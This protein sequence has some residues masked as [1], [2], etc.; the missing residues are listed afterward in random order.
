MFFVENIYEDHILMGAPR[1]HLDFFIKESLSAFFR[2]FY[3]SHLL[4]L[5]LTKLHSNDTL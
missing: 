3:H 5:L 4:S 2:N 1:K